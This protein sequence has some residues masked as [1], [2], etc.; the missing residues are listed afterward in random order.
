MRV[1]IDVIEAIAMV[2]IAT[3]TVPKL[4]LRVGNI[5]PTAYGAAVAVIGFC[6][7]GSVAA[8][9]G[10]YLGNSLFCRSPF[11]SQNWREDVF[12]IFTEEQKI[13]GN[14]Y[15]GEQIVGEQKLGNAHIYNLEQGDKQINRCQNPSPNG[16]NKE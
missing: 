13:V 14:G 3:G 1:V 15:Q 10:D 2:T 11:C 8:G 12:Y 5:C 7:G 16:K 6:C 9:E 4:Q